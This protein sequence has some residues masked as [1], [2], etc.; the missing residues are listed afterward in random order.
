MENRKLKLPIGIQTFEKLRKEN[1]VYVD[2]TKY[3]VNMIDSGSIYFLARP[4]RFG[5]SL[6]VSTFDALF[7]G[8]KELF[9]G[10]AAEE[11][12]NRPE[13]EP[14]PVIWLDMSSVTTD[15]GVDA[16][17][18]S[19]KQLTIE[20][21]DKLEVK[22]PK[23]L[24]CGDTL[25][26]LIINTAKKYN[27]PAVVLL[28]EY[29]KPYT[30]FVNDP[31]MAENVR[32]MLRSFY[33]QIKSND[34]YIR[35]TFITGISKFAKFGVFSTLNNLKDI[36]LMPKYAEICGYTEEEIIAYF[37]DYL[38]DTA[39]YTK[40]TTH[41]LLDTMRYQYNGFSF[42]DEIKARL[43]NPFSTLLFFEEKKFYNYWIDTGRS[44]VIAD[45]LKNRNLTVEEFRNYPI[46][47]DFARS[48][49]DVDTTPPEGFL[50]QCGYLTLRPGITDDLSLDYPNTEVL[51]AMSA[52][53]AQNILMDRDEDYTYC[54]RDLLKGLM[55][56]DYNIIVAVFNRLLASIPYDD[57]KKAAEDN[58]AGIKPQE[59]L[60]R[61]TL[62]AFLRG[63]GVAVI[64]EM[65]TNLGR[66]DLVVAHKGKTWVIELKVAYA[67]ESPAQKAEEALRQI[68]D[69]NY[70]NP[71]P[72]AFCIG[73]AID[74]AA[75]Q[76]TEV[77]TL[78]NYELRITNYE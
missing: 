68:M 19:V 20:A 34:R 5:K 57:F 25:R 48:P 27:Q 35:F 42:D 75:R 13:F 3:L 38:E 2:K 40:M 33:V 67:G 73:L 39:K 50:Y 53:L 11:F 47:I 6:T 12:L 28:D 70:A 23:Q 69:N 51:E 54:R 44:K 66:P 58:E 7:S 29:D 4:R 21:A 74:D 18:T 55:Y 43:Y 76:I 32:N 56:I 1:C 16:L 60:Y 36:S 22:V 63:C 14:S 77:R 59:W 61:S 64:A 24:P 26:S 71:Y 46:S 65:H 72:D 62:L 37:P 15:H 78:N 31:D 17:R 41:E 52:L 30:D 49:G 10:L 9:K 8:K 45:Y